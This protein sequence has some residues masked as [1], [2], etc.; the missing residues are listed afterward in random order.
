MIGLS[1]RY[2]K[3]NKKQS[4]TIILAVILASILL[5]SVGILFSSF[6]QY[7]IDETLKDNDY[8]VKIL[9]H[10]ILKSLL[11]INIYLLMKELKV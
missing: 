8:H 9:M 4:L 2:F 7:L 10:H 1:I 3:K 5:F 6:R 11:L